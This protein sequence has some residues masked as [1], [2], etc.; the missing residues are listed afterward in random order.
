MDMAYYSSSWPPLIPFAS[1]AFP[2]QAE[3]PL[4][5]ALPL[6]KDLCDV[7]V[8]LEAA[9][10]RRAK[11]AISADS[12]GVKLLD[13]LRWDLRVASGADLGDHDKRHLLKHEAAS[14]RPRMDVRC[15]I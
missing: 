15:T 10:H 6:V 12:E 7:I 14:E 2:K 1:E 3:G 11:S 9:M 5:R 8:P 4:A 13:K